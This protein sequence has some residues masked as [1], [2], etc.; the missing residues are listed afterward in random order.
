MA[1]LIFFQKLLLQATAREKDTVLVTCG[2]RSIT[3]Q[4]RFTR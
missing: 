1:R 4:N 3:V 2:R